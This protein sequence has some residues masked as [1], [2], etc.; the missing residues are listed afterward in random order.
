MNRHWTT[1]ELTE[2][3]Y[4]IREADGEHDEHLAACGECTRRF[5]E[6]NQRRALTAV[7]PE[8]APARLQAQRTSVLQRIDSPSRR[9]P[10]WVPALT[11]AA[12][13][14]AVAVIAH[15]PVHVPSPKADTGVTA[16]LASDAELFA[17]IYNEEESSEPRAAGP[18]HELFQEGSQ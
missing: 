17:D 6:L 11:A 15:R 13:L 3:L 16:G 1:D 7:F 18:M 2:H 12:G 5:E 14:L 10:G 9:V 4:G 8:I